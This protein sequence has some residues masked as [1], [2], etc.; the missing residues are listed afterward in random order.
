MQSTFNPGIRLTGKTADTLVAQR[1]FAAALP[2]YQEIERLLPDSPQSHLELGPVWLGLGRPGETIR[3]YRE[4]LHLDPQSAEAQ[5]RLAWVLATCGDP[6]LRNGAEAEELAKSACDL[7][8][9]QNPVAFE[10]LAA[11]Y[12]AQ[13]R[14]ADAVTASLTALEIAGHDG[15]SPHAADI[16]KQLQVYQKG[17]TLF[18]PASQ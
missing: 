18:Q 9:R 15:G 12:A 7:T 1:N 2:L 16:R 10:A 6:N 3:E 14:F 13:G 4:A 5:A 17:R 8:N 11:A